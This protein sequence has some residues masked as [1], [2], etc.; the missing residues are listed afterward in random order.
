MYI[1][2]RIG[3]C[4]FISNVFVVDT[5]INSIFTIFIVDR[6]NNAVNVVTLTFPHYYFDYHLLP[7]SKCEGLHTMSK[8]FKNT[9]TLI[10][11]IVD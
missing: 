2:Y 6:V 3:I 5:L 1:L 7:I 11:I 9:R 8:Y 10:A 4:Q